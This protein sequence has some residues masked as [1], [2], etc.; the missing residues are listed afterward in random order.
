MPEYLVTIPVAGH[1]YVAV[2]ADNKDDAIEKAMS[3]TRSKN[4]DV[5]WEE[6]ERFNQG[7][8][9]YCP[10]PWEITVEEANGEDDE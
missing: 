7:N 8:V 4:D 10:Q 1:V 2:E 6:L 9:C 5:E 3:R